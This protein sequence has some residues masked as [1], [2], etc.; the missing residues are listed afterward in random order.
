MR[1][2]FFD[3]DRIVAPPGWSRW[4]IPPAALSV[5]LAIGQAYAWSV[6]KKPLEATMLTDSDHPGTLSAL[7]FQLGMVMLGVSAALFGRQVERRGPR[8]AMAVSSTFFVSGLLVAS[9]GVAADQYWLVVAGYGFVGGIGLGI[10]YISPVTTLI[11]WFPDRPG[12][13]TGIAIMGFGGGALIASPLTTQLLQ[14]FDAVVGT[15]PN[16]VA[17]DRDGIAKTFLVLGCAYA[18]FMVMSYSLI[19]V[20]PPGWKPAGWEPGPER[21]LVTRNNVSAK[22]AVKTP[23]FWLLWVVLCFNVTAGIGI[24]ERAAPIY[25]DF[26]PG[27]GGSPAELAAA[28]AGFVAILSLSNSLGRILWSSASDVLGRRNMYRIYLGV[29]CLLYAYILTTTNDNKALFIVACMLIL[30]F[31][32][33]GFATV[34]AY[35]RDLFGTYQV[36][37]IHGRLLT[38]WSV[39]GVLGPIIV[40]NIADNRINGGATGPDVYTPAF[41]I[42]IGLL[43]V[44]FVCNELIR[45]VDPKW[46]EPT[47]Q[48]VPV[49][50]NASGEK[51]IA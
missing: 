42:V 19:R 23:Q 22:N 25:R 37:A 46:H 12:L 18:V 38:A 47:E 24:L 2:A 32:G 34:P 39:A 1:M 44:A 28:A 4:L 36:G 48:P 3:Q 17:P 11:K 40:N 45:P 41:A 33:A 51:A 13:A 50:A 20:P 6:F 9:V 29:G 31:Y 14:K 15:G 8:W 16:A 21:A 10:G 43:V 49:P 27:E 30:S 7:P 26:F 35:L 5:H